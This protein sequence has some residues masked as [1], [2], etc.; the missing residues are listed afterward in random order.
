MK[1]VGGGVV[2]RNFDSIVCSRAE[3]SKDPSS[4]RGSLIPFTRCRRRLLLSALSL[5]VNHNLAS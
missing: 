5:P 1:G 3:Q 4:E 2:A